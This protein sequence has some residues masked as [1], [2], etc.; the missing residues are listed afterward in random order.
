MV[1]TNRFIS[2]LTVNEL[3]EF[4]QTFADEMKEKI[5]N[6]TMNGDNQKSENKTSDCEYSLSAVISHKGYKSTETGHYVADIFW[7]V[8]IVIY[9]LRIHIVILND[10]L[11][12]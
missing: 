1:S 5:E 11:D 2:I 7:Y 10:I 9:F 12:S 4:Y 8:F 6:I 3:K